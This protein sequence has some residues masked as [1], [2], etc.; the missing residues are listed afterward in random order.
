MILLVTQEYPLRT[1]KF[2]RCVKSRRRY[3][4][5]DYDKFK[6]PQD[7][8]VDDRARK[9]PFPSNV[10]DLEELAEHLS[11]D[12][13]S[14]PDTFFD[15]VIRKEHIYL[16]VQI[17]DNL[18]SR[19]PITTSASSIYHNILSEGTYELVKQNYLA[20]CGV[21]SRSRLFQVDV[22]RYKTRSVYALRDEVLRQSGF[23][24][25]ECKLWKVC[26]QEA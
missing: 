18:S 7:W 23:R 15:N 12:M 22:G 24:D 9:K 3:A 8:P 6:E 2:G 14:I 10:K 13:A 1:W 11:T 26:L 4:L 16:L 25:P 19:T 5:T 20:W 21:P 17:S